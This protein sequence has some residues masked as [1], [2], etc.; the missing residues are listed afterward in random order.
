[1]TRTALLMGL[2][3][4]AWTAPAEQPPE[5][6]VAVV[7][8]ARVFDGYAMTKDLETR[9]EAKRRGIA[10]D[11]ENRRKS[12]EQQI[13]ALEAFDPASKDYAERR[14]QILNTQIE[15][16]IWLEVE[17]A[18]L[19][20]EHMSWLRVIY[21]DVRTAVA[22]MAEQ[23]GLDLVLTYD[24]LSPDV[25]D[26]LALR[27][28]ILLKKVLYFSDRID[29][30]ETVLDQ[31]NGTYAKRGG[32]ASLGHAPTVPGPPDPKSDAGQRPPQR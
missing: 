15:Y 26:S 31:L 30:S 20:E 4:P 9:F 32:A 5:P 18:R 21:N 2:L 29:L 3:L 10:D 23:R 19:K 16:R 13:S 24:E 28:E 17:E 6:K 8:L 27:R 22:E 7:N 12:L 11:A 25:P 1:M 14:D